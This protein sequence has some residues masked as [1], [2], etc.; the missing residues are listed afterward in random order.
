[1]ITVASTSLILLCSHCSVGVVASSDVWHYQRHDSVPRN[2]GLRNLPVPRTK[3]L[4][5]HLTN[6]HL[7]NSHL[8]LYPYPFCQPRH[9]WLVRQSWSHT[10][11]TARLCIRALTAWLLHTWDLVSK[12]IQ[13]W[14]PHLQKDIPCLELVQKY[15]T[16]LVPSLRN[17][18]SEHHLQA[19]RLT[20][21][22]DRRIRRDLIK[23]FKILNGFERI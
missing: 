12:T 9:V 1:M 5:W 3:S 10:H 23:T 7:A 19:P 17:P 11:S 4:A 18:S 22:Y 16:K 8:A 15:N 20:S 2:L 14:S 21:L 13:A 6:Y